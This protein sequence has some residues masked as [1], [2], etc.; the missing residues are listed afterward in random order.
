MILEEKDYSSCDIGRHRL[1]QYKFVNPH[2]FSIYTL[3]RGVQWRS[4]ATRDCYLNCAVIL[5][6]FFVA[7]AYVIMPQHM[8]M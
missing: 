6:I 2:T 5:Q 4:V 8:D 1:P 3:V 7:N